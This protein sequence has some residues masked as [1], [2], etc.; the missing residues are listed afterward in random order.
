MDCNLPGSFACGILQ[1][2]ILEWDPFSGGSSQPRDGTHVS[3]VYLHWQARSLIGTS[4]KSYSSRKHKYSDNSRD[5]TCLNSPWELSRHLSLCY[6]I[7]CRN[8]N[9]SRIYRIRNKIFCQCSILLTKMYLLFYITYKLNLSSS[10]SQ[11]V[12]L[13]ELTGKIILIFFQSI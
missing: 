9:L 3:Y 8:T 1:A 12:M 7:T 2:R 5:A 11:I 13:A 6:Q 4:P 10:N